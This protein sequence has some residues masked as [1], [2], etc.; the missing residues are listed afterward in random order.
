MLGGNITERHPESMP[1]RRKWVSIEPPHFRH[2]ADNL[3]LPVGRQS[4]QQRSGARTLKVCDHYRDGSRR[5]IPEQEAELVR[6]KLIEELEMTRCC[7]RNGVAEKTL[8]PIL[9]K[10]TDEHLPGD[11]GAT[12]AIGE[13]AP[14]GGPTDCLQQPLRFVPPHAGRLNDGPRHH[15]N[16]RRF[17]TPENLGR[18][19]RTHSDE[20]VGDPLRTGS[21]RSN[22]LKRR[23]VLI[24]G[25]WIS[26]SRPCEFLRL[27]IG[28]RRTAGTLVLP[29]HG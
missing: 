23:L 21:D 16:L 17:Q 1:E 25:V 7:I 20:K 28:I 5:L 24:L 8:A 10:R 29:A 19:I 9:A 27:S 14:F 2:A 11:F 6:F 26:R 3:G 15:F 4:T 18:P 12:D 22:F 13:A